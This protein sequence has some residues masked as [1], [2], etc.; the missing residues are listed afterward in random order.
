MSTSSRAVTPRGRSLIKILTETS[1]RAIKR[2][3]D[4][5]TP[6]EA[7]EIWGHIEPFFPGVCA[8]ASTT[9]VGIQW[10]TMVRKMSLIQRKAEE[11]ES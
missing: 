6:E 4:E 9:K 2:E 5:M 1:H 8:R 3:V 10:N 7:S 11:A